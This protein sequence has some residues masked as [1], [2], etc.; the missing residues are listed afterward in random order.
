MI[1]VLC[2]MFL[3][4]MFL[5]LDWLKDFIKQHG[6]EMFDNIKLSQYLSNS[7]NV[8]NLDEVEKQLVRKLLMLYRNL[9]FFPDSMPNDTGE[10]WEIIPISQEEG[11][12][13]TTRAGKESKKDGFKITPL[14]E[15]EIL[16]KQYPKGSL[17]HRAIM[18]EIKKLESQKSKS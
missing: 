17:E 16:A 2:F 10:G 5:S 3:S 4:P 9:K 15:L 1:F 7:S 13:P 11:T 8:K 18:E 14:Q 12:L 6:G